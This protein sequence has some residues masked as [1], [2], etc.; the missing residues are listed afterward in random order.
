VNCLKCTTLITDDVLKDLLE[1]GGAGLGSLKVIQLHKILQ[2]KRISYQ[3][4]KG[5]LM[6]RVKDA[7]SN[8]AGAVAEEQCPKCLTGGPFKRKGHEGRHRTVVVVHAAATSAIAAAA[9]GTN[10]RTSIAAADAY[11]VVSHGTGGA[12]GG[13]AQAVAGFAIVAASSEDSDA[14]E[15]LREYPDPTFS[16]LLQQMIL[17]D[18]PRIEEA[19]SKFDE[20][21]DASALESIL[22]SN[23]LILR[24]AQSDMSPLPFQSIAAFAPLPPTVPASLPPPGEPASPSSLFFPAPPRS[25]QPRLAEAKASLRAMVKAEGEGA[26]AGA[27]A[28]GAGKGAQSMEQSAGEQGGGPKRNPNGGGANANGDGGRSEPSTKRAKTITPG[29]SGGNTGVP[30]MGRGPLGGGRVHQQTSAQFI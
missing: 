22:C 11:A 16:P 17:Q 2:C 4:V 29:G 13:G 23:D 25:E 30:P 26:E 6:A 10:P 9:A 14:A 12:G 19:M 21:G 3:G 1:E 5:L 28:S 24:A 27:V 7:I 18:D 8:G 20:D 15:D